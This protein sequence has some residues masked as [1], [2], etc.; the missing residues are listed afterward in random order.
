M[1]T[2]DA[3]AAL[4]ALAQPSRLE[5]FRRLVRVGPDGMAAGDIADA[6]GAPANTMS[7]HLGILLRAGLVKSRRDGRSIIYSADFEGANGLMTFLMKDCCQGRPE[8][9]GG[10]SPRSAC[11]PEPKRRPV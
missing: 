7:A 1:D 3:I 9:C 11:S 2:T 5:V 8:L 4:S 10:A 6:L